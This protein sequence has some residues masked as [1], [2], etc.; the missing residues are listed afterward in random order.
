MSR[1]TE[2]QRM[3]LDRPDLSGPDRSVRVANRRPLVI[4]TML[5]LVVLA[6]LG[7]A[8]V[9][10]I[11]HWWQALVLVMIVV[12]TIGLMIAVSPSRRS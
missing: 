1:M 11:D 2:N 9:Q 4:T 5:L 10:G 8:A 7:Y 12:T 6:V 3:Q